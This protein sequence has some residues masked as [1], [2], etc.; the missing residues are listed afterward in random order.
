MC[1]KRCLNSEIHP[2]LANLDEI[3]NSEQFSDVKIC[4]SRLS[5]SQI[6]EKHKLGRYTRINLDCRKHVKPQQKCHRF[7]LSGI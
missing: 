2:I 5:F 3:K 7:I 1:Q 6:M 4:A